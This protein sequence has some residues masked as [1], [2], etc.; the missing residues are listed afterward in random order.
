MKNKKRKRQMRKLEK[1]MREL[2]EGVKTENIGYIPTTTISADDIRI[3]L[4]K[5]TWDI[6]VSMLTEKELLYKITNAGSC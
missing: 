5:V 3:A 2:C 4:M 6:R 1:K